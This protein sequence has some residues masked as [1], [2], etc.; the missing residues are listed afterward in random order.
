SLETPGAPFCR[1][2]TTAKAGNTA[3]Q[4]E[5]ACAI[6]T[7]SAANGPVLTI[8][9]ADG[10]TEAVY[11]GAWARTLVSLAQPEWPVL[12]ETE[13]DAKL[14]AARREFR[15]VEAGAETP[16]YVRNKYLEQGSQAALTVAALSGDAVSGKLDLRALAV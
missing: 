16:W 1:A 13:L 14:A 4:N 10:A 7:A 2:W 5:D 12:P 3:E 6:G 11:S 8:A 9:V 15:P